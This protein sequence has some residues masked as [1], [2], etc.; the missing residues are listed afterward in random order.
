VKRVP[1]RWWRALGLGMLTGA[2]LVCAAPP[3][4]LYPLA[5][6]AFVP[7]LRAADGGG[8]A[9][10]GLV[11]WA[12]GMVFYLG[13]ADWLPPTIA[14]LQGISGAAAWCVFAVFAAA[15][16]LQFGFASAATAWLGGTVGRPR[17]GWAGTATVTASLWVLLDWSF[18]KVFPWSVGNLLGPDPRLRQGAALGGVYGLAL[19]VML[20]N[21]LLAEGARG[22]RPPLQRMRAIGAAVGLVALAWA[23]GTWCALPPGSPADRAGVRIAILQGGMPS[24]DGDVRAGAER[25]LATYAALSR[26][27]APAADLLVWPENALRVYLRDNDVFATRLAALAADTRR[28][29]LLGALDRTVSGAGER[30]AAYLFTPTAVTRR[31]AV[32]HKAAL[33][34]FGEYVPGAAWWSGLRRWRTTGD[35][36]AGAPPVPLDVD[37][38]TAPVRLAPS[39][40]FEAIRG[41]AFNRLVRRGAALL[42]NLTDDGWFASEKAAAQ[43]LEL[44]RL[45]AVETGRWLVRASNSGISAFVDP[46][47]R[48]VATLPLGA[49]GALVRRVDAVHV[50]TPYVRWGDWVVPLCA[51]LAGIGL[52]RR[53][54]AEPQMN[55]DEH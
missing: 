13:V 55:T 35:F 41:G 8:C 19:L 10:A 45:R 20:V 9:T 2:A 6:V 47:G 33:L 38:G 28:P 52:V 11:G 15:H 18:P 22:R 4:G 31:A 7:L 26:G 37:L 3:F 44:T 30:N 25:A 46:A 54:N 42:V 1:T 51:L 12:A 43:H 39:I 24:A 16:A 17:R 53:T 32:Y 48:I 14:R 40:C 21:A 34:P 50:I 27:A 49:V 29:L 5:F 23:C 36:V